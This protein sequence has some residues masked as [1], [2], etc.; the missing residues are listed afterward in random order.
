MR[1]RVLLKVMSRM[2]GPTE[3]FQVV[4]R[5]VG[6]VVISVMD[7]LTQIPTPRT[8]S[9]LG[10]LDLSRSPAPGIPTCGIATV[11]VFVAN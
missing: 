8:R 11:G 4:W 5:V 6:V 10:R 1:F 9:I 2:T 7:D 3:S